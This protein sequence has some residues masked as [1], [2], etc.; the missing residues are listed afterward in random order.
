MG[1]SK[2]KL[3]LPSWIEYIEVDPDK[4]GATPVFRG[5]RISIGTLFDYLEHGRG[6]QDFIDEYELKP[7]HAKTV[8]AFVE[9]LGATFRSRGSWEMNE[10]E[11][12][13]LLQREPVNAKSS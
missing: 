4:M 2:A 5:T 11:Q 3:G 1:Y 6:V 13:D 7:K 9:S 8:Y 10:E 12:R